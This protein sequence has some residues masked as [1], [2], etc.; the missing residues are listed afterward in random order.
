[1][2]QGRY[3]L[4][5]IGGIFAK[6]ILLETAIAATAFRTTPV[7]AVANPSEAN[8]PIGAM[9]EY[10]EDD[11]W[12]P[13][14]SSEIEH[15]DLILFIVGRGNFTDWETNE[16]RK[17]NRLSETI[18]IVPPDQQNALAYLEQN[19]AVL[20]DMG[21]RVFLDVMTTMPVKCFYKHGDTVRVITA[22]MARSFDYQS[23][24]RLALIEK[25]S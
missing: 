1:M 19:H 4:G 23:A 12:Q 16:I 17:A 7:V 2:R 21:G 22:P 20:E 6:R 10:F 14:I 25:Q 13:F 11:T 3:H 8:T 9:R 24:L 15:S 18:F 5:A